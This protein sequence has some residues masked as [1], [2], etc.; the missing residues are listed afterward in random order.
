MSWRPRTVRPRVAT[1]AVA[2]LLGL[3]AVALLPPAGRAAAR[4]LHPQV[5]ASA[6]AA[7]EEAQIAAYWTPRRR[8]RAKPLDGEGDPLASASFLPVD[9]ATE[10]P[11]AANGRIFLRQGREEGYCSGTVI[12]TPSRRLVLTAGHCVNS[13]PIGRRGRSAWSRYIEF[14]PAYTDG[15][16]PFGIFVAR[17]GSVFALDP[18]V[19]HENSNFDV[20]AIVTGP[21]QEGTFPADAVGGVALALD[22][23]RHVRFQTFGYPGASRRLQECDSPALGEDALTRLWAGPP[24]VRIGC[25]WLPGASGGGW[26][27][28]GGTAIDGLTSYG[29]TRG[30]RYTFGPY[31]SHR[32]VG[33][34]VKGL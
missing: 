16:T 17:R 25:R 2:A 10:P 4:R 13:G 18:W 9:N 21:N 29:H 1:I 3:I 19:K 34:L 31:F 24:T 33:A 11:F 15:A 20:G 8:R 23:S 32:N 28:E 5:G 27:I 6:S 30:S 12:D 26:L 14:V 7:V 22:R